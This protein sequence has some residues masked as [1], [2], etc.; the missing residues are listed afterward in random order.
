MIHAAAVGR[1]LDR[2]R[3]LRLADM[4]DAAGGAKI[5]GVGEFDAQEAPPDQW[6]G[7]Q[8]ATA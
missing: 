6:S 2:I 3:P 4:V 8:A 7:L 5:P 1:L